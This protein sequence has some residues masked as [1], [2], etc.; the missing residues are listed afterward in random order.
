MCITLFLC[1]V[2]L[3]LHSDLSA[4]EEE[5][6]WVKHQTDGELD[7]MRLMEGLTSESAVYKRRRMAKL[8][9]R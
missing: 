5:C 8:K 2:V 3:I 4:R 7:D 1:K 6:I 9:H